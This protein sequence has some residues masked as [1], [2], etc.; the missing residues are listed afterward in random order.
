MP[1]NPGRLGN[2]ERLG[3]PGRLGGRL[4]IPMG[5]KPIIGSG[6]GRIS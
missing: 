5:G 6:P 4:G 1:G 3:N 2:P